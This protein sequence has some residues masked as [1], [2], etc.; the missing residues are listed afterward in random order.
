RDTVIKIARAG[1]PE[2]SR[3][4]EPVPICLM[5][6]FA[7]TNR[8]TTHPAIHRNPHA[9]SNALGVVSSR[10]AWKMTAGPPAS[11]DLVAVA[12]SRGIDETT[13]AAKAGCHTGKRNVKIGRRAAETIATAHTMWRSAAARFRR[14]N[15]RKNAVAIIADSFITIVPL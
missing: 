8:H 1:P 15:V 10:C 7:A 13:R 2:I 14:R 5:I 3:P 4:R 12:E 6:P 11:C 9:L